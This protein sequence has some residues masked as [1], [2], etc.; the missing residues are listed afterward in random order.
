MNYGCVVLLGC[1]RAVAICCNVL[2]CKDDKVGVLLYGVKEKQNPN[3]FD[4]IRL[5]HDLDRPSV[6]GLKQS[7][8][9]R[10]RER[11]FGV[12]VLVSSCFHFLS[13]LLAIFIPRKG[14][15]KQ[16][17][18]RVMAH[19]EYICSG[20]EETV[21]Y[22]NRYCVGV[23]MVIGQILVCNLKWL[24]WKHTENDRAETVT[25]TA[26]KATGARCKPN[27][28]ADRGKIRW[29]WHG[30]SGLVMSV[31]SLQSLHSIQ[32]CTCLCIIQ[33]ISLNHKHW[34]FSSWIFWPRT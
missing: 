34:W 25:G 13:I 30:Q 22:R 5:L 33:G 18:C 9:E 32:C 1:T 4:G 3:N 20:E 24:N 29:C 8:W 21:Q 14:M 15:W 26:D 19:C 23:V 12:P 7:S 31:F 17:N 2:L 11:V 6:F 10:E 16:R 28:Q 27:S